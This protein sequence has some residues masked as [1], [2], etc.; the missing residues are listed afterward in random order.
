MVNAMYYINYFF[1][2]SIFGHLIE[3][4]LSSSGN[5][6]ILFGY[7]T[8]I[9]GLG[10][11]VI[12]FLNKNI[13]KTHTNRIIK[14]ILLFICSAITLSIIESAGGYLIK[15]LFDKE[16]WNYSNHKFNIGKY[17]SLEMSGFWGITSI[18]LIYFIKPIIDKIIR[19]IPKFIS[20]I[21]VFLFTIDLLLTLIIKT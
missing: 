21:L 15:R 17:A 14:F 11:V 20:Y 5:S 2:M 10:T 9:Y 19:K 13:E 18:F 4:L 3:S 1:I 6:G 8:P 16:L 7:W 12:L